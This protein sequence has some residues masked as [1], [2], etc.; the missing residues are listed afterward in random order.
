MTALAALPERL[1]RR[2]ILERD[3]ARLRRE[4]PGLREVRDGTGPVALFVSL[5]EFVYQL[6]L[7]G[8]LGKALQL[9]GW[10]PVVLVQEQSWVPRRYLAA[11]GIESFV[12]LGRYADEAARAVAHLAETGVL[13]TQAG[14]VPL[15]DPAAPEPLGKRGERGHAGTAS[16]K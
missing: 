9:H 1:R 4:H 15:E 3:V 6:K 13:A 10:K 16:S 5:T 12:E 2:G 11:F 8:M 14:D 7:E